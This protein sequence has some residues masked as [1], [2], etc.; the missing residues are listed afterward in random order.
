MFSNEILQKVWELGN[1][2]DVHPSVLL[3]V[4]E[5]ESA[6]K[7]FAKVRGRDEPL[8]RFEGHYFDRR[9]SGAKRTK[10]RKAG[11]SSPRVGGV[12]NPRSQEGR[13][14]LLNRAM[15][16]DRKAALE[17]VSWGLGQ[18]MGA[19]WAWLGYRNVDALMKEA[20]QGVEGQVRLMLKFIQKAGLKD[21]MNR[22]DW[23]GFARGYNGPA[24]QKFGYHTK[25]ARA[26]KKY[27]NV[28]WSV[29][30][31][32]KP[33]PTPKPTPKPDPVLTPEPKPKKSWTDILVEL[34]K[35]ILNRD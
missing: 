3:T 16:V 22:R 20:R 5:V 35:S 21:E 10:A 12:P 24:Y 17:S 18:V 2:F 9:L 29:F 8:I 19:H 34:I 23:H 15:E 28:D 33:K 31:S 27:K 6:G 4:I 32:H 13:W 25:M 30:E 1:E 7:V 11:L 26:Y 14:N